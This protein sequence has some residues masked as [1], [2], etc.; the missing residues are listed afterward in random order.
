MGTSKAALEWHGS[1]L[2]R[3]VAGLVARAVSGPVVVVRAPEQEL[4][5]LPS[6]AQV[7]DDAQEGRGPLQ[8][9]ASGLPAL[10]RCAAVYVSSSD[11]PF[12]HPVFIDRLF[13]A[14]DDDH[15]AV[16]PYAQGLPQPLAAV[17][18]PSLLPDIEALLATEHA[19]PALLLE[20]ARSVVLGERAL[21]DDP[22]LAAADSDLRSLVNLN[23]PE[24]Y[25][26]AR[27]EPPPVVT[28]RE[29]AGGGRRVAAATL[30]A[31]A[32]AVGI[33]LGA[34]AAVNDEPLV[35]A[36]P[37]YPLVPGDVIELGRV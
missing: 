34:A 28:V 36:D 30:T 11:C 12:L 31:A 10:A 37:Y 3:H 9:I 5:P 2:L 33:A 14:L 22:V 19:S 13:R 32:A 1:T 7:V 26:A 6:W 20:R 27:A 17:Y 23:E 18:R 4:P 35:P 25:R 16:L 29:R 15:D 24:E 21:L 8:G